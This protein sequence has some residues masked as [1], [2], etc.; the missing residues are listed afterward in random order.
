MIGHQAKGPDLGP[1]AFGRGGKQVEVER[2]VAALEERPLAAVAA[3]GDVMAG[4]P[5]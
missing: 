4:C 5:E 1:R 3:L 2:V